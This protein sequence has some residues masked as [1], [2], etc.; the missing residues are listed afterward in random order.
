MYL[1]IQPVQRSGPDKIPIFFSGLD[2]I[3]IFFFQHY[4]VKATVRF[5]HD[6]AQLPGPS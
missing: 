6:V 3:P 1:G 4:L 2:K 5:V